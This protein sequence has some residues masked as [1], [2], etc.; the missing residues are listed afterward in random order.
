MVGSG[1]ANVRTVTSIAQAQYTDALAMNY[2][3]P[4]TISAFASLGAW[5]SCPSNEERDLH[6]WL[7]R[8]YNIDL[9]VYWV[10]MN[11]QVAR[12][13]IELSRKPQ[14]SVMIFLFPKLKI[15][16]DMFLQCPRL[17]S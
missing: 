13:E 7:R 14:P 2:Q 8:L 5:G 6:R 17:F 1:K 9:E 3:C 4:E 11:L 15:M 16:F 12:Y 10:D